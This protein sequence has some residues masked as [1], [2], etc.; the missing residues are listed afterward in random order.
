[1]F[2]TAMPGAAS[3][4]GTKQRH[5]PREDHV[6]DPS[7]GVAAAEAFGVRFI[8]DRAMLGDAEVSTRG[9]RMDVPQSVA[10]EKEQHPLKHTVLQKVPHLMVADVDVG[11]TRRP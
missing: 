5:T 10:F 2:M 1:M 4:E 6:G 7:G 9:A 3:P 11:P 8:S